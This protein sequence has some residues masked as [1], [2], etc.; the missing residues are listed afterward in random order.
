MF[1]IERER[2]IRSTT[3]CDDDDDAAFFTSGSSL[4]LPR[5]GLLLDDDLFE[6]VD[7]LDFEL[8]GPREVK[9]DGS[10]QSDGDSKAEVQQRIAFSID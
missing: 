7:K 5:F 2:D 10:N 9:T 6:S 3:T 4:S 1:A 8:H